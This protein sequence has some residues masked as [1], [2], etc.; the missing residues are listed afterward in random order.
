MQEAA[1]L[2]ATTAAVLA[3]VTPREEALPARLERRLSVLVTA[4][5]CLFSSRR[6]RLL[7][8]IIQRTAAALDLIVAQLPT[9][10]K[11]QRWWWW[12]WWSLV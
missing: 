9:E 3:E 5:R 1:N 8:N 2:A 10:R 4:F 12:W 11:R 6:R 7:F